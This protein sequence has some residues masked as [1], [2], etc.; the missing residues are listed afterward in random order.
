MGLASALNT[1]LTGMSASETTIGVIGNNLANAN[2]AG[3]KASDANFATQFLQT[4]TI[5]SSPTTDNYGTN[6][7]QIGLGALV[8]SITPNFTQGTIQ[9]AN[10][11]TDMAIQGDGFFTVSGSTAEQNLYTRNGVFQLNSQNVLTT[12]TGN[13]VKGWGVDSSYN[14]D[15]TSANLQPITIPLGSA[16]VAQQT[17]NV[18]L[19]GSLSPTG[20]VATDSEVLQTGVLGD[21]SNVWPATAATAETETNPT[22]KDASGIDT[23]AASDTNAGSVAAGTYDYELVAVDSQ[24]GA[25]ETV[26]SAPSLQNVTLGATGEVTISNLPTPPAGTTLELYR[27]D[28]TSLASGATPVYNLVAS[29][30]STQTPNNVLGGASYTD[31][32][33]DTSL[34]VTLPANS[35]LATTLN[36]GTLNGAYSYYVTY[37]NTSSKVESRP[38][39]VSNTYSVS[40]GAIELTNLPAI[41]TGY[42]AE[43]IYRTTAGGST[44]YKVTQLDN[45]SPG[46]TFVDNTSDATISQNPTL[47]FNDP[48]IGGDTYAVNVTQLSGS[49]YNKLFSVGTLQFNAN[50]G[51]STVATTSMQITDTTTVNDVLNFMRDSLGIQVQNSSNGIPETD[52]N[53]NKI[54]VNCT[55]TGQIQVVGNTG[56]ANAISIGLTDLQMV[57]STGTSNVNL[58]FNTVQSATGD[59]ASTQFVAYDA[60]GTPLN[61]NLTTVLQ[62]QGTNGAVYRWYAECPTNIGT[63]GNVNTAVGTGTISFNSSG[64][65]T[66]VSNSQIT[67]EGSGVSAGSLSFNLDFSKMSGLAASSDSLAVSD[68]DGSA[69]GSLTSFTISQDGTING[70]FSNGLTRTLGQIVVTTFDNPAGLE[71]QGDNLYAAGVNSGNAQINTPGSSGSGTIQGGATE[72]SNTDIG[73]NLVD[74]ILASTMYQGNS[75]VITTVNTLFNDLLTLVRNG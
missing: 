49:T 7:T 2:T 24:T 9:S 40:G 51:G 17:S 45:V 34:P 54:G 65:Y 42:D 4:Q 27:A 44:Y 56:T 20:A 29:S 14:I 36:T 75:Q 73:T 74:L 30:D 72:L 53:G 67:I 58:N 13:A 69:P 71:Q 23:T 12:M 70:V 47:N 32:A 16:T 43:R 37:Y 61:I 8:A 31:Q 52:G 50:V 21:S 25:Q 62:S 19:S 59:S 41:P 64:Q 39:P 3:F 48:A 15:N 28:V 55:T 5:G 38:S 18:S 68:Q 11:S 10:Q 26:Y 66:G 35:P 1:A 6:P 60:I 46:T 22:A 57:S 63:D 33:A